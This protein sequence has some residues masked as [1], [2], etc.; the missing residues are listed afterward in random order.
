MSAYLTALP[1]ALLL[2]ACVT[3]Q[4]GSAAMPR[5]AASAT[6]GDVEVVATLG[7]WRG[8]P[9]DLGRVV[10]P[11]HVSVVNRSASPVRL[12]HDD[13]TLALADGRRLSIVLPHEVRGVVFEPPPVAL[14]RAGFALDAGAGRD[15]VMRGPAVTAE[16]DPARVGEQFALP[17]PDVLERA[18]PEGVLDAG[19]T[20]SGF[21]YFERL[22]PPPIRGELVVQLVAA[23]DGER[24]SR[25]V[26]PLPLP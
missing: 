7:A 18:L 22:R 17:S 1:G 25:V 6:A 9:A 16:A 2:A 14:P 20:A 19:Q 3:G 26:V 13:C 23:H 21:L 24:L 4:P 5:P 10:T 12:S 8:W 15:W 11:V